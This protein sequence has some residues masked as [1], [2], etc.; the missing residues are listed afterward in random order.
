MTT[1][2][3][4]VRV[5]LVHGKKP[6][7]HS[8]V[9]K[10]LAEFRAL[11]AHIETWQDAPD[12]PG[13]VFA[14]ADLVILRSVHPATAASARASAPAEAAWC[15]APAAT[16]T[17]AD[18]V[19][20][21]RRLAA[22]GLPV[23]P[24]RVVDDPRAVAA[25]AAGR[26]VVVKTP[27]GS[28]G[29]GVTLLDQGDAF[30]AR[31][32]GPWLVQDRIPGDGWDRKLFVVGPHVHGTLRRW[33]ARSLAEKLG[34]PLPPDAEMADL[35]LGAGRVFG[36]CAYGVDM[37]GGTDG[38]VIVDV[39]AFPG[40]K[41]VPGAAGLVFDHLL[42]HLEG[43]RSHARSDRRFREAGLRVPG[44]PVPGGGARGAARLPDP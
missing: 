13:A 22:A 5:V 1:I 35:A 40:F 20:T 18:R 8:I 38:P 15:N 30:P 6:T 32:P 10:V 41:G 24:A 7:P 34:R 2:R 16:A 11:G 26:P 42:G 19:E 28:R 4:G 39:N 14:R 37:M 9:W 43:G 17:V 27:L 31:G 29:E 12:L 25:I 44:P 33:P 23:P 3:T 21:W 36:L